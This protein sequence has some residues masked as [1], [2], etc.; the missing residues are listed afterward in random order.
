MSTLNRTIDSD[1]TAGTVVQRQ[2][3]RGGGSPE[4]RD[5]RWILSLLAHSRACTSAAP[6]AR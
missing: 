3:Q 5:Q 2:Y 4:P 1:H 6:A